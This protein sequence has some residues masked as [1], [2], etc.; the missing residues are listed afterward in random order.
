MASPLIDNMIEQYGYPVL[1]TESIDEFIA[2]RDECVLFFT[3][4][5]AR[6]PESNDVAMILP[7]LVKEYGG[8]FQAAVIDRASQ[9]Q[10]QSRYGFREWPTLVFVRDG[11]Y[12][13]HVSRVQDWIDYI[14]RINEILSS[15]PKSDP[16]FDFPVEIERSPARGQQAE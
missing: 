12:L 1:K 3:E 9:R 8:R 2:S 11:L 16:G 14:V 15:E 6:F 4:D 13:G 5:P 7:E 10:L